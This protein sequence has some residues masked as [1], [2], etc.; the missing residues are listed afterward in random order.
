MTWLIVTGADV[1]LWPPIIVLV[2]SSA[3]GLVYYLRIVATMYSPLDQASVKALPPASVAGSL[4]LVVL[5]LLLLRF[6]VVPQP[7]CNC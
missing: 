3:I 4:A 6:G 2:I 7:L 1:L 5:T